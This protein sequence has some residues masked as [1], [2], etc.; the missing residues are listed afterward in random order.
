MRLFVPLSTDQLLDQYLDHLRVDRALSART[1]SAYSSDLSQFLRYLE[2]GSL[3]LDEVD[4]GTISGALVSLAQSGHSARSQARFLS[5]LRGFLKHAVDEGVLAKDPSRLVD[6]PRLRPRLPRLLSRDELFRLLAAPSIETG[7]G[8][9]D[10]AMLYVLYGSGLRVSELVGLKVAEVD[11]RAGHVMPLGK[12]DKRRLIPLGEPATEM[13][14]T[15]LEHV[16]PAW[17]DTKEEHVFLTSRRRAMSRQ[18][19]WKNLRAYAR[20]VGI[21]R[22]VTPHMLRHSFATH[23]LQGG[24]DLRAVQTMLGHADIST[25]QIYTHVTGDHIRDMH[26]RYHPRG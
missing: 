17:A 18:G 5:A 9:R 2:A 22:T 12:G 4:S 25:T 19:F 20:G 13:L 21:Q 3:S 14:Q 24:A 10:V 15:Y 16:R 6:A 11:L 7:R 26:A 8:L 1:L 23:L